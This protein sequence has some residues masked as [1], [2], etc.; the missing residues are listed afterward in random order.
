MDWTGS[1]G[2]PILAN[3]NYVNLYGSVT[4]VAGMTMTV[5]STSGLKL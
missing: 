2:G 4:F 1:L 3:A 5:N